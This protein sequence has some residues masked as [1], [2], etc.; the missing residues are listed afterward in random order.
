MTLSDKINE[1]NR[2]AFLRIDAAEPML[3]GVESAGKVVPGM[4]KNLILHAGPPAE[5]FDA[6]SPATKRA[7]Q[8][9]LVYEGLA[10]DP[11]AALALIESGGVR[12]DAAVNHHAAVPY[13][14]VL[15]Y[16]MPV[17]VVL[18]D[19]FGNMCYAP[20]AAGEDGDISFGGANEQTV[21]RL[22]FLESA[23]LPVLREAI[24]EPIALRALFADSLPMGD[25]GQLRTRA[26]SA[27]LANALAPAI[28]RTS[29]APAQT[30]AALEFL[31]A[32]PR[33]F[34]GLASA[35]AKSS[36]DPA[37]SIDYCTIATAMV[38]GGGQ[39]GLCVSG[40]GRRWFL[41]PLEQPRGVFS[42]GFSKTDAAPDCGDGSL[43][44]TLGLG[45]ACFGGCFSSMGAIGELS[46][47]AYNYTQHMYEICEGESS[48]Y[49]LPSLE[50]RG[51]AMGIDLRKVVK[52]AL[53]P[54]V[55][56]ALCGAA[57]QGRIGHGVVAAA[58]ACF[59]DALRECY[60]NWQ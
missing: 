28:W 39:F 5:S 38:R 26:A 4:E 36:L 22:G 13:S 56:S 33:S 41:A 43:L 17:W 58:D 8:H 18:N 35:I 16:S 50:D 30:A 49:K 53:Y 11:S 42:P 32:A 54:S 7:A 12:F 40:L 27:L 55:Y 34:A 59:N 14:G 9:A 6:L 37:Q 10:E 51:A 1:A 25:D 31:C 21:E 15:S 44:E 3:A 20:V 45:Y 24:T 48:F 19:A 57:G 47:D 29:F 46:K 2:E 60:N 23:I 52:T